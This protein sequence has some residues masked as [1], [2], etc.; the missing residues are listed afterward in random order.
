MTGIELP[1]NIGGETF[2]GL[3][4]RACNCAE[5][6]SP[7]LYFVHP[8]IHLLPRESMIVMVLSSTR[9]DFTPVHAFVGKEFN[10]IS[11]FDF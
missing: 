10:D 7:R 4:S 6:Y 2:I 8:K 3:S 9:N 1:S 11:S 5:V